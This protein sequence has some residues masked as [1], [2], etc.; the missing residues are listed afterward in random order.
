MPTSLLRSISLTSFVLS[1]LLLVACT[2]IPISSMYSLSKID[3]M[4]ADPEQIRVAIRTNE[5]VNLSR[6]GAHIAV[7]FKAEDQNI[8]EAFEGIGSI[9]AIL[10][11]PRMY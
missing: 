5:A 3:P 10:P 1:A 6:D 4:K 8:N 7:S 11:E 9:K 2:S